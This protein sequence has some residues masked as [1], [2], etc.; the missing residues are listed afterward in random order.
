[1]GMQ[2]GPAWLHGSVDPSE[3][4]ADTPAEYR[5]A[6]FGDMRQVGASICLGF[7]VL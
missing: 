7:R 2:P 4:P 6:P 1:M 3:W 5:S